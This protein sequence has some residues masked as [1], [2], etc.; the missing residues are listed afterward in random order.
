MQMRLD[1]ERLH[2]FTDAANRV[3]ARI[4]GVSQIDLPEIV[5]YGKQKLKMHTPPGE[6]QTVRAGWTDTHEVEGDTVS[7]IIYNKIAEK[8]EGELILRVLEKGS[9]PHKIMPKKPGGV[10]HFQARGGSAGRSGATLY[11]DI[12][13]RSVKHPGTKPYRMIEQT[14]AEVNAMLIRLVQAAGQEVAEEWAGNKGKGGSRKGSGVPTQT[15][16]EQFL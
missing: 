12:F 3:I 5:E 1:V 6:T 11:E 16:T 4:G 8:K 14:Q 7:F 13:A 2:E 10:L 15:F 9:K